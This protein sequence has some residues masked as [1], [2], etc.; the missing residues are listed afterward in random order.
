MSFFSHPIGRELHNQKNVDS[1]RRFFPGS[2]PHHIIHNLLNGSYNRHRFCTAEP[3]TKSICEHGSHARPSPP[4]EEGPRLA[5]G[6]V[7]PLGFGLFGKVGNT[8]LFTSCPVCV[9]DAALDVACAG[10]GLA[11]D[12]EQAYEPD[13]AAI[14]AAARRTL[15]ELGESDTA[16]GEEGEGEEYDEGEEGWDEEAEE[17]EEGEEEEEYEGEEDW[18][19]EEE[20]QGEE[21][22]SEEELGDESLADGVE[23]NKPSQK[24]PPPAP[25]QPAK[26]AR[27]DEAQGADLDAELAAAKR[28]I[29]LLEMK[30]RLASLQED[31]AR[32]ER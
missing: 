5:N 20:W 7:V 27:P 10:C 29:A 13:S 1:L 3:F 6:V 28:Q 15:W 4:Q 31:V 22:E 30:K 14:T 23:S 11:Y 26:R 25:A 16:E 9:D 24:K 32:L 18:Q 8:S 19:E 21:E 12:G 17:E 2:C